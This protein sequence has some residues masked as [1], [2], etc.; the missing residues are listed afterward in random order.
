[1]GTF[2][3]ML[4]N[5]TELMLNRRERK[6]I[7][8]KLNVVIGLFYSEIGF[9]LLA[10]FSKLDPQLESIKN[11]LLVAGDWTDQDFLKISQRL[12][13]YDYRIDTKETEL[14]ALHAFFED[15]YTLLLRIMENPNLLEHESFTDL[16]LA[17]F[18]LRE[19]LAARDDLTR[20]PDTDLDHLAGDIQRAYGLL[21][22]QW[23]AYMKHLKQNYP[24]LFSLAVR[25]NPFNTEASAIVK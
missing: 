6:A 21:V 13:G 17:V 2:L 5:A 1:M 24:Y 16:L 8:E 20:L 22:Q 14:Q 25:T 12:K 15:R 9:G 10:Y 3:G 18:H 23:L 19:E 7:L 4:A 11:D